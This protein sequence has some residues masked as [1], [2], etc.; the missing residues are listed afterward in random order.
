VEVLAE[1]GCNEQDTIRELE[2][3]P[4]PE[5]EPATV[6][7]CQDTPAMLLGAG[8]RKASDNSGSQWAIAQLSVSRTGL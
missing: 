7:S 8:T 1:L 2:A 3:H 5:A 4:S 6:V